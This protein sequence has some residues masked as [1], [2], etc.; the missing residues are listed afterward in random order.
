MS[1]IEQTAFSLST[2]ICKLPEKSAG[3]LG[4]AIG[5]ISWKL[6]SKE[7]ER[8]EN[9]IDRVY[10][11]LQRPF[12]MP[13]NLIVKKNFIHFALVTIELLRYPI[14]SPN[15]LDKRFKFF[16]YENIEKAEIKGKGAILALPHIGNW[17]YLG[18]ALVNRGCKLHSF[19]LDQKNGSVGAVLDHFRKYSGIILHDRDR[20]GVKALKALKNNEMLGMITDQDGNSNGVYTDF[21]E[22]WVSMPAGPANWSLKT[23]AALIPLFALRRGFTFNYDAY[24]LPEFDEESMLAKNERVMSRTVKLTKWMED[25]I[26]KYPHQYLWFYD[27]FKP[28]HEGYLMTNITPNEQ[29]W[30]GS[31]RYAE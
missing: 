4:L 2:A 11:R 12:P 14:L 23:G 10:N 1:I 8:I 19:Y 18:A 15:D 3:A 25:I 24:I 20:G 22:H 26:L 16:G 21:L 27:R 6:A 13:L 30:H 5:L 17:E 29:M 31:T 9:N 7:R 28:R